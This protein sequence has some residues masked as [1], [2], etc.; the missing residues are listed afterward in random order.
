[1]TD[2]VKLNGRA[3]PSGLLLGCALLA[4]TAVGAQAQQ[5]TAGDG[6]CGGATDYWCAG[7]ARRHD[8][9]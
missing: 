4:L 5:A 3:A 2:L 8:H 7:F 6:A 9:D 1:M